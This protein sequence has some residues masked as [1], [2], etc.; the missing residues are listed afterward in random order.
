MK[1]FSRHSYRKNQ[2]NA[3]TFKLMPHFYF[4]NVIYIESHLEFYQEEKKNQRAMAVGCDLS[5][6]HLVP[7][8]MYQNQTATLF[9]L[10]KLIES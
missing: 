3:L 6:A 1:F 7:E 9:I 8:Y 5:W 2:L 10:I 4:D